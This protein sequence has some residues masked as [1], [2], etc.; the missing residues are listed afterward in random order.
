MQGAGGTRYCDWWFTNDAIMIDTAGRYTSQEDS[1][2]AETKSWLSFLS[3]LKKGR[4][5]RPLNGIIVTISVRD[6]LTKTNTQKSLHAKAI[7]QRVQELNHQLNME[8][9]VYVVLT[10]TDTIAGFTTFFDDMEEE[11]R[12]QVWGFNFPNKAIERNNDF[13][14]HFNNEYNTL[15]ESINNH[16]LYLS[17]IHI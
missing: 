17:L 9:P 11:D 15:I 1:K 12:K 14:N 7:K 6:I 4:P 2:K 8:L 10:K 5:K 13:K 16:V 3:I